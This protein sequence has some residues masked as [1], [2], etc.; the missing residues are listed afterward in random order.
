MIWF[1]YLSLGFIIYFALRGF[2]SGFVRTFFSFLGMF[3]AFLY[4][5]WFSLK[6]KPLV[7]FF[8]H[9]PKGQ[10][11]ISFLLAFLLIY[12]TFLLMGYL[13]V[14][15]LKIMHLTLGDRL[16]GALLGLTKGALFTTLLYFLIIIPYPPA[17]S[18]LDSALTYPIVFH[19]TNILKRFIP[20]SWKEY[21]VKSRK[22]YEIPKMFLE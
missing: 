10:I 6:I 7:A 22:Y 16:I 14:L 1:D 3:L 11:L 20:D 21:V 13:C 12:L 18:S 8:L 4:S 2:L 17:K 9:H 5:G 15:F 19:T